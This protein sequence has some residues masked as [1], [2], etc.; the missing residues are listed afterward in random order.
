MNPCNGEAILFSGEAVLQCTE[1]D[2]RHAEFFTSA[3]STGIG[4]ESGATYTYS[5]EPDTR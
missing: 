5:L 3:T 2:D 4:P 1:L